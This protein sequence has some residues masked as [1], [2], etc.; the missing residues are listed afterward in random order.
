MGFVS[1]EF[2]FFSPQWWLVVEWV[3]WLVGFGGSWQ[4]FSFS[5]FLVFGGGD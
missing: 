5:F 1:N 3:L 4:W 2:F